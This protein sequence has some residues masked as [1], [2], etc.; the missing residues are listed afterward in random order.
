MDLFTV[1]ITNRNKIDDASSL[2]IPHQ[3]QPRATATTTR[4]LGSLP[5]NWVYVFNLV[6]ATDDR[7][8]E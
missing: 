4:P 7:Q 6:I 3:R 5:V 1:A 2:P 8:H